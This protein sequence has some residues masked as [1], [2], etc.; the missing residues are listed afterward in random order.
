MSGLL[1]ILGVLGLGLC[2]G[3]L[4]SLWVTAHYSL[5]L[6]GHQLVEVDPAAFLVTDR[7]FKSAQCR[8]IKLN[9]LNTGVRCV[10]NSAIGQEPDRSL[11]EWVFTRPEELGVVVK[12]V[13]FAL[14][15][16]IGILSLLLLF[17][18]FLELLRGGF[19]VLLSSLL[20]IGHFLALSLSL[21][22]LFLSHL[23]GDNLGAFQVLA[24]DTALIAVIR[25][26]RV[27]L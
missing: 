9:L 20:G 12:G 5:I 10:L 21:S 16:S 22:P 27:I 26:S 19:L 25:F 6:T 24:H 23:T 18:P 1:H 2:R 15:L 13:P 3:L 4:G 14:C 17:L 11:F 7:A 8:A